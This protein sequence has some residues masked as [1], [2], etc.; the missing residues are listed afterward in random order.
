MPSFSCPS[1]RRALQMLLVNQMFSK[2]ATDRAQASTSDF[3]I[4]HILNRAGDRFVRSRKCDAYETNSSGSSGDESN[5]CE[6]FYRG[7]YVESERFMEIP[8]FDWLNY[9]RYNMPRLPRKSPKCSPETFVSLTNRPN[10][11]RPDKRSS[12][13]NARSPPKNPLHAIP[14]QRTRKRLHVSDLLEHRGRQQARQTS[15]PHRR[16]SENLV[17]E[18]SGA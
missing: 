11:I 3:S 7:G 6:G 18:S 14:A 9:T 8:A 2:M 12:K 13:A 17:P 5:G 1:N 10:P 15:R 16:S 4:D